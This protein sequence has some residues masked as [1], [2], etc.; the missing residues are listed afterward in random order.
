[1]RRAP[2]Y[3]G[4][5]SIHTLLSIRKDHVAVTQRLRLTHLH[6]RMTDALYHV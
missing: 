1:V 4:L 2:Q 3:S 6:Q 5:S